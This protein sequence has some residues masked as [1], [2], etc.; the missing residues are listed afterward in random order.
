M[1][2]KWF[3]PVCQE[4]FVPVA[5]FYSCPAQGVC[6]KCNN[7]VR[8]WEGVRIIN[9]DGTVKPRLKEWVAAGIRMCR[10]GDEL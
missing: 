2:E 5:V 9:I 7:K 3:C 10:P 6:P 1:A 4:D 8:H